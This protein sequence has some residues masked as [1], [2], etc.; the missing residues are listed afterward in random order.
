[1]ILKFLVLGSFSLADL[2]LIFTVFLGMRLAKTA[3]SHK[4][5]ERM[6]WAT[7]ATTLAAVILTE[8]MVRSQGKG[9]RGLLFWIHL[10]AFAFP[11]LASLPALLWFNGVS[12]M[13]HKPL[14]YT[15]AGLCI[16]MNITGF[17]LWQ[18]RL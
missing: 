9:N 3:C 10:T 8:F 1:M 6:A 11:Y 5:H 16:G 15:A 4:S 7:F 14:A 13:W 2:C 12:S 17:M 18:Q